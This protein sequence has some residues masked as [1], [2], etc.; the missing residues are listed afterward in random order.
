[1]PTFDTDRLIKNVG[2]NHSKFW[3][4]QT[5]GRMA[6]I[7][8]GRI[9]ALKPQRRAQPFPSPYA[10]TEYV[11][12]TIQQKLRDG[13]VRVN[14]VEARDTL[15]YPDYSPALT[16]EQATAAAPVEGSTPVVE[17]VR[18]PVSAG[19]GLALD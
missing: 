17:Q 7:T 19:R 16:A 15:L 13:Y 5:I 11:F 18:Q 12:K 1:M 4:G 8:Y 3:R 10:A 14:D 9:G 2:G 6:Y